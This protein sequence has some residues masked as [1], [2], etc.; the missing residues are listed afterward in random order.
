MAIT[1]IGKVTGLLRDI[2]FG[3]FYG[4]ASIEALAFAPASTLPR[5]FLDVA[6]ASA[7]SASFIPVFAGAIEK[8]G[9][10]HA[11]KTADR[12]I[13]LIG[14]IAAVFTI[15][16][17]LLAPQITSVFAY[18]L[19]PPTQGLT[20]QLLVIM[21]PTIFLSGI[22]FSITGILQTLGE[23]NIPASMSVLSNV[24]IL[25]YY[26][27][28]IDKFGIFGLCVA[29]ILGWLSQWLIQ[30]LPLR[31]RGYKYRPRFDFRHDPALR[32]IVKLA[33]P[34]LVSS[35]L[36]PL[37]FTVNQSIAG[38]LGPALTTAYTLY[39]VITGVFVLSIANVVFPDF[40]RQAVNSEEELGKNLNATLSGMV[41][42]LLPMTA[43]LF[44]LAEPLV[45]LLFERGAFTSES[46][47]NTAAALRA[48]SVG[49]L[50]Y[51]LQTILSRGFYAKKNGVTP[52]LTGIVAM[53]I[54]LVLSLLLINTIG[55]SGPALASSV[56]M[57]ATGVFM[58]WA[59]RKT[60]KLTLAQIQ[61]VVKTAAC[62]VSMGAIVYGVYTVLAQIGGVGF[63]FNL[64][65]I[66]ISTFIGVGVFFAFAYIMKI[67]EMITILGA[68]K[69]RLNR[70]A[71]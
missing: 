44:V 18:K 6:F 7:I 16:C 11:F 45:R 52:L 10:E 56:S 62:A 15:T 40:S 70:K 2:L 58:L 69:T 32:D 66:A 42:L 12:F 46:T 55:V 5:Q 64:L 51:G 54:N 27:F 48:Y 28:F 50:G 30:I 68:I 34:V 71:Q 14:I 60:V 31:K 41:F 8:N 25:A 22:A 35:W 13:T 20:A 63:M 37:N 26:A 65:N 1:L 3:Y 57:L 33:V 67:S 23:F 49:M 36:L 19:D 39:T 61:S 17:M 24:I 47:V 53:L 4:T 38:E 9:R 59:F 21:L 43:G 29:F